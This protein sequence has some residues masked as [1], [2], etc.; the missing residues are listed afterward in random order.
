MRGCA[1]ATGGWARG[2]NRSN[3]PGPRSGASGPRGGSWAACG[4]L[5]G[6]RSGTGLRFIA[7]EGDKR[8]PES[9]EARWRRLVLAGGLPVHAIQPAARL[10]R[11]LVGRGQRRDDHL[12]RLPG[13]VGVRLLRHVAPQVGL[14]RAG[15]K[16][17]KLCASGLVRRIARDR[18][19]QMGGGR[20]EVA[21]AAKTLR[22]VR[23]QPGERR[24]HLPAQ[25]TIPPEPEPTVGVLR[26]LE[27]GDRL[28]GPILFHPRESLAP[29]GAETVQ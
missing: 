24:A 21:F 9:T 4:P 23:V 19:A 26:L 1:M 8:A 3:W 20:R 5:G 14:L 17:A 16:L 15:G 11:G 7:S 10:D 12:E 29:G 28:G 22:H 6:R 25:R 2:A 27:R 18:R 13:R